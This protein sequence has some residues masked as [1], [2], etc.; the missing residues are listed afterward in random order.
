MVSPKN[1]YT[2]L[3]A[4]RLSSLYVHFFYLY[5]YMTV[6]ASKKAMN[7]GRSWWQAREKEN[8]GVND[9]IIF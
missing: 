9:V 3:I 8:E 7:L 4:N 6:M 1:M 2:L 5:V